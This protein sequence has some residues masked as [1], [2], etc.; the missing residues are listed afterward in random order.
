MNGYVYC[1][2]CLS[3]CRVGCPDLYRRYANTH[4]FQ[5]VLKPLTSLTA[6]QKACLEERN[7]LGVDWNK[8]KS[9]SDTQRCYF[10]YPESTRYG[11][12]PAGAYCC[13]H[14]RR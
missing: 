5:G 4:M 3:A 9:A 2:K 8:L 6:C 11:V 7:C 14:Y 10:I 12:Q 13:D 1:V